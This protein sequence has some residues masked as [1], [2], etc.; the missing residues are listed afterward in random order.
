MRRFMLV[1]LAGCASRPSAIPDTRFV[2]APVVEA[3]NDRKDVPKLPEERVLVR[4]LY[5]FD[6]SFFRRLTRGMELRAHQRALGLTRNRCTRRAS[7]LATSNRKP[8]ISTDSPR[9]G[10]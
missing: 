7:A 5:Q 3:V 4:E 2:N 8:P 10:K 6:G 1:L 9:S